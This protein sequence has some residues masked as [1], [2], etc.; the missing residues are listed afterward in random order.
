MSSATEQAGTAETQNNLG[1]KLADAGKLQEAIAVYGQALRLRP[2]FPEAHNNLG[3]ALA[4][5]GQLAAAQNCYRAALQLRPEYAEAH[6]NLGVALFR[7]ELIDQAVAALREAVRLKPDYAAAHANLGAALADRGDFVEAVEHYRTALAIEPQSLTAHQNLAAALV[8]LGQM[9]AAIA[10]CHTVLRLNPSCAAIYFLLGELAAQGMYSFGSDEIAHL[11]KL[12]AEPEHR[13]LEDANYLHF[14]LAAWLDRQ[15]RYE[16]AFPHYRQGNECRRQILR[17]QNRTY[18]ADAHRRLVDQLIATFDRSWFE[19][20]GF[21]GLESD[22]PIFV[23]GMP[24]S[25]TTLVQQILSSHPQV[26]GAGELRYLEQILCTPADVASAA[27]GYP[28]YMTT[29]TGTVARRLGERYLE[30]LA[31]V[32][33]G[34]PRVVDKMPH[35][36]LHLGSIVALFPHTP[37]IH[38]R[39]DPM[40]VCLSCYFQNFKWLN[41]S[42]SLDELAL[43]YREYERLMAHWRSVLPRPIHEVVYEELVARPEQVIRE[44]VAACGLDWDSRCLAFHEN[45]RAVRTASKL[46]V[47]R[48]VYASSVGRWKRYENHLGSLRQALAG[49]RICRAEDILFATHGEAIVSPVSLGSDLVELDRLTSD[50]PSGPS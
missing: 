16:E 36:Y 21:K 39:R 18:D 2:D 42:C 37:I 6:N 12:L 33:A 44:L 49:A 31:K 15:G 26:T 46:Q 11:E 9:S 17:Q 25:G 47:R 14:T 13:S 35:N 28:A 19:R 8:E 4:D 38:C 41:Y 23:V 20:A 5:Q 3:V 40:D 43:H 27:A 1:V 45:R 48:P 7:Q 34:K 10:H 29:L 30:C 32:S 24:R 22:M 50:L